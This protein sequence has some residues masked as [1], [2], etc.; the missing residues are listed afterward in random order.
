MPLKL[1]GTLYDNVN[2]DY[3]VIPYVTT[4]NVNIMLYNNLT[5]ITV[6]QSAYGNERLKDFYIIFEYTKT[7]D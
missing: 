6:E 1:S 2:H 5:N 7:T 3:E 4:E